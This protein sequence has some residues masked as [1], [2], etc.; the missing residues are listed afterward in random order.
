[1][2]DIRR[3]LL[4]VVFS[5]SLVLI[6]DAW[7]KHNGKPSMF[8]GSPPAAVQP[9]GTKPPSAAPNAALPTP[10]AV[11]GA[12]T[13]AGPSALPGTA[14]T[15]AAAPAG[16]QVIVTTDLV[17][18]TFDSK[19]ADL[20]RLEL[21]KYDDHNIKGQNV[22]LFDQSPQ[23]LYKSQTG[24]IAAQGGAALPNHLTQMTVLP[25]KRDF[26]DGSDTLE[27]KFE[28][29]AIGGAKLLKTYRFKRGSYLVAVRHEVV[30]TSQAPI[31]P[32]LY[33]Q[34]VR[35]GNAPAG[36]SSFYF[37]FTGPALYTDDREIPQGRFQGHREAPARRQDRPCRPRPTTAGW[38]WCSI[39][40]PRPGCSAPPKTKSDRAI[41]IPARSTPTS[42]RSA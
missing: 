6:W 39:I 38:R 7:N 3:T 34:L 32:Q 12:A 37:T 26:S 40:S 1:M 8:G 28:S 35:D 27:V 33:L 13:P 36:E 2:T 19:G 9:A 22:I 29:P 15:T 20:V 24:L 11:P 30:N 17:K 23:R 25:G 42:I 31:D 5:M 10:A 41:S 16:E 14:A 18:A 4:W 21:L